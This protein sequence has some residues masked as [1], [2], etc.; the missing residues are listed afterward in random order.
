LSEKGKDDKPHYVTLNTWHPP[1]QSPDPPHGSWWFHQLWLNFVGSLAGW[2]AL[3]Y[4]WR[5]RLPAFKCGKE[6]SLVGDAF[7]V[8]I[9]LLGV[10]GILPWRLFNTS[11]K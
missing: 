5:F 2:G 9:A 11:I 4:L 1:H 10:T 7:F 6:F 8:L 3:F